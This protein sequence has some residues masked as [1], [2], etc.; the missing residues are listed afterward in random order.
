MVG[1]GQDDDLDRDKKDQ[2]L[3]DFLN[4][5]A[6][7]K[8]HG[9]QGLKAQVDRQHLRDPHQRPGCRERHVVSPIHG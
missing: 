2:H 1:T 5:Q 3:G 6:A 7:D 9:D 4:R 8:R